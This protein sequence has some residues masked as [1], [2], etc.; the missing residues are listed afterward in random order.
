[1]SPRYLLPRL[2]PAMLILFGIGGIWADDGGLTGAIS[3]I[4]YY[5]SV[6][7]ALAIV[8]VLATAAVRR[9]RRPTEA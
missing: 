3:G 8:V 4:G 2:V 1:M 5:G 9:M 7:V 6:A